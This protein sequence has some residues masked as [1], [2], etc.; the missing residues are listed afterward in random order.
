MIEEVPGKDAGCLR[1]E[2]QAPLS[3]LAERFVSC[4]SQLRDKIAT[5]LMAGLKNA[6]AAGQYDEA[7][8]ALQRVV[9]PLLDYSTMQSFYRIRKQLR[10]KT[11]VA[12]YSTRLA[13]L[14][15]FTTKQL[16]AF[17]DLFLFAAG[18]NVEIYEA[19]YGVFRHEIVD[20]DSHLYRF[21]PKCAWLA[22]SWRD[23][24]RRPAGPCNAAE[25]ATTVDAEQAEW[26]ALWQKIHDQ[27][28]CQV[29]QDNFVV[30]PWRSFANYYSF[31]KTKPSNYFYVFRKV[32]DRGKS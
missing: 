17:V 7:A 27:T 22:T 31:S 15:S 2:S 13:V 11:G 26:T 28:Q 3:E 20:P 5:E 23:L 25:L 24:G 29:I 12:A 14:G 8:R 30:P 21:A 32:L 1:P 9:S 6:T 19:E 4:P 18:I 16:S 10:D